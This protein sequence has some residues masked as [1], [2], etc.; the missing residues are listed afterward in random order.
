VVIDTAGLGM[1]EDEQ[2]TSTSNSKGLSSIAE[3]RSK[4][5]ANEAALIRQHLDALLAAG[6]RMRDIGIITP[7]NGQVSL[8]RE[9]LLDT[10][11][12]GLEIGT[13]DGFQGK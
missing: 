6:V 11:G 5:N 2:T 7:Y 8:L 3:Q 1:Y 9:L 13:V 4:A 12:G 10:Y